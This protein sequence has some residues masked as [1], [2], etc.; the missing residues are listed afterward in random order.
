[1]SDQQTRKLF[2]IVTISCKETNSRVKYVLFLRSHIHS[3]NPL[4]GSIHEPNRLNY[5]K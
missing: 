1:M 5:D 2:Y 4:I 3:K